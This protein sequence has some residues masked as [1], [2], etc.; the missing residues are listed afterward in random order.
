M[1]TGVAHT[2]AQEAPGESVIPARA[3]GLELD[4]PFRLPTLLPRQP[5]ANAPRTVILDVHKTDLDAEWSRARRPQSLRILR[6]ADG[7]P[8]LSVDYDA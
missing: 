5:L 4:M 8:Y 7:R 6:F 1:A 3:F 2:T